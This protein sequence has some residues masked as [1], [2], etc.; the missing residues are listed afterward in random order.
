MESAAV[1]KNQHAPATQLRPREGTKLRALYDYLMAHKG[2]PLHVRLT[3]FNGDKQAARLGI[4]RDFYGLDIRRLGP[5]YG[6]WVL[7]GEWFGTAYRDYI[8]DRLARE[9]RKA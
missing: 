3:L 8:A 2:E 9:E 1:A 4:L 6:R 7:A 5:G